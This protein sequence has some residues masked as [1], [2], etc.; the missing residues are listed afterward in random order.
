MSLATTMGHMKA[1]RQGT[2]TTKIST[3]STTTSADDNED[4]NLPLE[5]PRSHIKLSKDHQ[6][7]FGVNDLDQA[8][9]IK[10]L[11]CTDLPVRFSYA[12]RNRNNYIFT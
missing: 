11:V 12:S 8:R 7:A 1:V 4:T 9:H 6:V 10:G 2:R 5:T 3:S